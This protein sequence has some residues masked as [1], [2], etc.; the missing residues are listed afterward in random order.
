MCRAGMWEV[1]LKNCKVYP[2]RHLHQQ[3][4]DRRNTFK[5]VLLNVINSTTFKLSRS[6]AYTLSLFLDFSRE[7]PNKVKANELQSKYV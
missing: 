2:H 1:W 5:A 7:M 6:I 3:N 4:I